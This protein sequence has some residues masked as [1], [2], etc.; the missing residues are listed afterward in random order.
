[1]NYLIL[2]IELLNSLDTEFNNIESRN[3]N[4]LLSFNI[5]VLRQLTTKIRIICEEQ[6]KH[7]ETLHSSLESLNANLIDTEF[8]KN[9]AY[10]LLGV[11]IDK[12]D[13]IE[14][15]LNAL[16]NGL[17]IALVDPNTILESRKIEDYRGIVRAAT[18][19]LLG[20]ESYKIAARDPLV[21]L[22]AQKLQDRLI[23]NNNKRTRFIIS[24]YIQHLKH[25]IRSDRHI[26]LQYV[27]K[28]LVRMKKTFI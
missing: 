14:A 21:S 18:Q 27:R 2:L 23:I 12:H 24:F 19:L 26:K 28:A 17:A 7:V 20:P 9:N 16:R 13:V 25:F 4:H 15:E 5:D 6:N 11:F 8:Q 1:M 10:R 3:G 22:I